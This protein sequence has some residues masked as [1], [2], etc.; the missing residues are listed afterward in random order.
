MKHNVKDFVSG[1]VFL[2]LLIVASWIHFPSPVPF[3]LQ[4]LVLFL[5][6]HLLGRKK[7]VCVLSVYI[8]MGLLS[9]PVFSGFL[10]GVGI[11]YTYRG[12]FL[13]GF[14]PLV[15]LSCAK[16]HNFIWSLIGLFVCH[17]FGIVWINALF[18]VPFVLAFVTYSLPF[19]IK[20]VICC[21]V[22]LMISQKMK[23][24]GVF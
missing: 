8:I 6:S 20:D 23:K 21:A 18:K 15:I 22:S 19:L 4:T 13:F 3:T 10:S 7:S 24:A 16:T 5:M 14:F 17:M 2:T 11:F 1:A 12:G 9:F